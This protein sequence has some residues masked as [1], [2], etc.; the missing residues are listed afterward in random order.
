MWE[1]RNGRFFSTLYACRFANLS[2]FSIRSELNVMDLLRLDAWTNTNSVLN[3]GGIMFEHAICPFARFWFLPTHQICPKSLPYISAAFW[4]QLTKIHQWYSDDG[5]CILV[6]HWPH[7][8]LWDLAKET[9]PVMLEKAIAQVS[10]C[11]A[12]CVLLTRTTVN[13]S[14]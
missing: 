9:S 10:Q 4:V 7:F 13:Y 12:E 2:F 3:Q 14:K 8:H 6:F 5:K 11:C 1:L